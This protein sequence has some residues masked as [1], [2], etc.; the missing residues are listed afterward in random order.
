MDIMTYKEVAGWL[1]VDIDTIRRWVSA[2]K[3]P[4]PIKLSYKL[5]KFDKADIVA[6]LQSKK[7]LQESDG[8]K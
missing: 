8:T 5:R 1:Q 7:E 6:W 4:K 3:F 2:G